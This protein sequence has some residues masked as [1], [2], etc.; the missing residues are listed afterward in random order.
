MLC[1][2]RG[3]LPPG[4]RT[5]NMPENMSLNNRIAYWI[6]ED[7]LVGRIRLA[8]SDVG[9]CKLALGCESDEAF[10]AWLARKTGPS[11]LIHERTPLADHA[12]AEINAYL[13]GALR[14]FET[15]SD[16]HGTAFQRRVWA[17]VAAIPYGATSTYREVAA[18]VGRP[19]AFRA[20]GAANAANPVP[21]FV[22]CHRVVG[23]DGA[24][25]GYGGGMAIKADLLKLESAG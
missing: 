10:F 15:P 23:A 12:L 5:E 1:K 3:F 11:D 9:V 4:V 8:V 20:V 17:E 21:L 22:P 16:L 13:S 6:S 7:V 2:M 14:E 19:M 24:L 25:R 18:R